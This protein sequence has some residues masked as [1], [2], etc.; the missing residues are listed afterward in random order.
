MLALLH[1]QA[2]ASIDANS[3]VTEEASLVRAGQK[4]GRER[5][6]RVSPLPFGLTLV[7]L[8]RDIGQSPGS[9]KLFVIHRGCLPPAIFLVVPYKFRSDPIR[10]AGW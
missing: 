7:M 1:Y 9:P 4:V 5:L 2:L 8:A 3:R 10:L 6:F